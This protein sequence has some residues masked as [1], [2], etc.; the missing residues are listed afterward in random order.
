M[1]FWIV[2][3]LF[4]GTGF[5]MNAQEVEHEGV[6]YEI[7]GKSIFQDGKDVTSTLSIE[8]KKDLFTILEKYKASFEE[9]AAAKK[10]VAQ[11]QKEAEKAASKLAKE[12]KEAEKTLKDAQKAQKRAQKEQ[13]TAEKELKAKQRAQDNFEK[14][15]RKLEQNQTKYEKL[16]NKGKLSPNDDEKWLKSLNKYKKKVESA[17]KKLFKS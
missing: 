9:A 8:K 5:Y 10:L 4:I 2:L 15:T 17:R 3:L 16:K 13:K 14:A 6:K 7:K 12:Q 1:K 11:E